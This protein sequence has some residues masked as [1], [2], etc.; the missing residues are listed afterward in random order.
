MA[1]VDPA[2]LGPNAQESPTQARPTHRMSLQWRIVASL[3]AVVAVGLVAADVVTWSALRSFLDGRVDEQLQVASVQAERYFVFT[4]EKGIKPRY[5]A[6]SERISTDLYLEV[7]S[8]SGKVLYSR[9]SGTGLGIDPPPALPRYLRVTPAP[10]GP[11]AGSSRG[12]YHPRAGSFD[13]PAVRGKGPGYRVESFPVPGG[14][15]VLA[16]PLA[17]VDATLGSLLGIEEG[18]TAVVLAVLALTALAIV[19]LGLRPLSGMAET[20]RK[21]A[22][23]DLS[24]RV[25]VAEPESEVGRLG[26][27]LN[28]MLSQV[29]ALLDER[30]ASEERLRRFVADASHELR[31]PITSIRGY[32]ELFRRGAI[33]KDAELE[34]AMTRI[35]Q[36][37][38]RM[39]LLVDD[40]VLLARLDQRRPLEMQQVD[41]AEVAT[42]AVEDARAVQPERPIALEVFSPAPVMGDRLRLK[43][44]ADNLLR[45]ALYHTPP[46]TAVQVSVFQRGSFACLEVR[47][48][49]PGMTDEDLK[50]AFDRF[51]RGSA[52]RGAGRTEGSG[53]GL[54]IVASIS[55]ALGGR[56][57]VTRGENRGVIFTV[58]L[59]AIDDGSQSV[60]DSRQALLAPPVPWKAL[61]VGIGTGATNP[62][63]A[64]LG[65]AEHVPPEKSG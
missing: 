5:P 19:R 65:Q 52:A 17:P 41:L 20:A 13:V 37:A 1:S 11:T 44:V 32:A 42:L 54:A 23:G 59:P 18:V 62:F 60:S 4:G 38:A 2:P 21:I 46:K 40:L 24:Q 14:I 10:T 56:T 29:E 27:A 49:G 35:E 6:L 45:N 26:T 36:E 51:F 50:R 15:L 53:L 16:S 57:S 63:G 28:T 47:D 30:Q 61:P 58:E 3:L 64:D 9:P 39:G 22:G 43:Q 48:E 12:V 7:L 8:R 25:K 55:R 34:R 33:S 31:T